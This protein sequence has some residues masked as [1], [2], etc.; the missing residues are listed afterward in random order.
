MDIKT[1]HTA[2][3]VKSMMKDPKKG[4]DLDWRSNGI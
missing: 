3:A 2:Y 4:P 1:R